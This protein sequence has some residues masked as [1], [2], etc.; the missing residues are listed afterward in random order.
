MLL[1]VPVRPMAFG[2]NGSEAVHAGLPSEAFDDR[3]DFDIG[4]RPE[5]FA[6]GLSLTAVALE[7]LYDMRPSI[8]GSGPLWQ[9][10]SVPVPTPFGSSSCAPRL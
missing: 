4:G 7:G 10:E 5:L 2:T 1:P 6:S 9:V 3:C 8:V